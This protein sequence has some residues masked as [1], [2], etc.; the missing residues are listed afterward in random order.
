MYWIWSLRGLDIWYID[1]AGHAI[2][3]C[4]QTA[5]EKSP[6]QLWLCSKPAWGRNGV[7][8]YGDISVAK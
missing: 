3:L 6:I 8:Q 2:L 1:L 4:V 5:P 7:D